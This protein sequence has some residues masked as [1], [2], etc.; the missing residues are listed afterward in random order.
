MQIKNILLISANRLCEPYPVY[1]LALS[2]LKA[3]LENNLEGI[4]VEL[5]DLNIGDMADLKTTLDRFQPEMVG[6]SLRNVDTINIIDDRHFV[7]DC[8]TLIETIKRD[9][10]ATIVM[11]GAGFSIFPK[12]IYEQIHPDFGIFGEGESALLE[13]INA[14][15]NGTGIDGIE[16]LVYSRHDR[17]VINQRHSFCKAPELR[18]DDE[19]VAHYWETAGMLNIQTKRGCPYKCGYCTYPLIEGSR[20]RTQDPGMLVNSIKSIHK[21]R[22]VNYFFFTDSVFNVQNDFNLELAKEI[23]KADLNIQWGA[24]FTPHNFNPELLKVLK[25]AGLTHLEFG[26]ESLSNSTLKAYNKSFT[27]KDVLDTEALV[28][29][30]GL[31][32]AHFLIIGGT[33]ETPESIEETIENSTRID[34]TVLFP[35]WGMRIYPQTPLQQ[36]AIEEGVIN[37]DDGLLEPTFYMMDGLDIDDIKQKAGS[38]RNRWVFPDEDLQKPMEIMR[39]HGIKGP[40]WDYLIRK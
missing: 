23:I 34:K 20:I 30:L 3:E 40:L 6:V 10:K 14:L 38:T 37:A 31:H 25:Q 32:T 2:Y 8:Q 39:K 5:F 13:L 29:E 22:G 12:L 19:L 18:F 1:P 16:G 33:G 15:N 36:Q 9:S 7:Q 24:Y 35:F 26:T 17:T 28:K 27:V 4:A 21:T 11:G